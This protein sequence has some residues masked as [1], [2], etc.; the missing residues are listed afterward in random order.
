M[1]MPRVAGKDEDRAGWIRGDG[2]TI[3][4]VAKPDVEHAGDHRVHAIFRMPM[5]HQLCTQR[6]LHPNDVRPWF[7]RMSD[8]NG[9]LDAGRERGKRL[10]VD[11]LR[12]ERYESVFAGLMWSAHDHDTPL[13][14]ARTLGV[15]IIET[16]G[17]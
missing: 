10:P 6:R 13:S 7:R 5:R 17:Q 2:V 16:D 9:L 8:D 15:E 1:E 14:L 12:Q 3:E 11:M 4:R